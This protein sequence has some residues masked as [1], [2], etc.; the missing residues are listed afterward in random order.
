MNNTGLYKQL[1]S[2]V[3]SSR[4]EFESKLAE[5]VETPSV[6][7]DPERRA[8]IRRC[9]ELAA[10]YLRDMGVKAETIS[11][12]GN[13][14]VMAANTVSTASSRLSKKRVI[15]AVVMVTGPPLRI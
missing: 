15:S 9:G 2:Y 14:V 11:T 6:S 5:L 4:S 12:P 7:S 8:D 1:D 3:R 10:Q 13:P